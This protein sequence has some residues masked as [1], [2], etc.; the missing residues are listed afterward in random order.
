MRSFTLLEI[1][2]VVAIIIF[3][4]VLTL[5]F[6]IRFYRIQQLDT[7]TDEVIQALRRAQL[8]AMSQADY[9]FG[10]YV[11]SGRTG[12][13]VLFRGNSY[14]ECED[15]E[16]FDIV[17][18]ISFGGGITEVVFTKL[19]GTPKVPG[20]ITLTFNSGTK[21]ITINELGRVNLEL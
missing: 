13:Y 5:P 4:V 18:D 12:Q 20:N 16:I 17:D 19:E 1:L 7:T 15:E 6:G 8:K 10:V 14:A 9:S 2:I 21:T 3:L 11:G